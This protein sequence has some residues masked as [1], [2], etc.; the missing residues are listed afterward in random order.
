MLEV[1][2]NAGYGLEAFKSSG[3]DVTGCEQNIVTLNYARVRLRSRIIQ[4]LDQLEVG[5]R[6]DLILLSHVLEH[7]VE[8]ISFLRLLA[9]H[10]TSDG[11]VYILVPNYGSLFV[12]YLFRN[13]W[14]GFIPLQHVW[15]F[16]PVSLETLLTLSGF[17]LLSVKTS[18]FMPYRGRNV[19]FTMTK[20]PLAVLQRLVPLQGDELVG[21]FKGG[22]ADFARANGTSES[23]GMGPQSILET[24]REI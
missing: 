12:R 7:V 6:F 21:I 3:W 9:K 2:C 5:E 23:N 4:T 17:S 13:T 22:T 14:S 11:L 19:I 15:Y 8:P 1:G 18:G 10:L 24:G 20:V 16:D